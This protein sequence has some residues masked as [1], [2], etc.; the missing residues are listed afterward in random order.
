MRKAQKKLLLEFIQT[1]YQAQAQVKI[2]IDKKSF[3]QAGELLEQCQEGVIHL[4]SLIEKSEGENFVTVGLLEEYCEMVYHIYNDI[5]ENKTGGG[6]KIYKQL[7]KQLIRIENSVKSD[8]KQKIEAVFLP[9]NASM[10]DSLESVWKAA[11]EAEDCDAYVI[12]IPYY[13]KNP[14]GSFKEE[15]WE[16]DQ[17]PDYVPITRYQDYSFEEHHPDLIFI[18][19]PYDDL[20]MVT[21]V[22]PFF[23]SSNLKKY[24]DNLIYIPY[25]I[26]EEI[27]PDDQMTID[28]IQ[29][30]CTLPGVLNTDKVIVQSEGIRQIYINVLTK[31]VGTETRSYWEKKILGIGS[32]KM[33]KVLSTVKDELQIPEEWMNLIH[34]PD[35]NRKKIV[36]YNTSIGPLLQNDEKMLRKIKDVL[37][38]FKD[39]EDILTL[40]WRP[41]PLIKDT[42]ESMRP[43]LWNDYKDLVEW[44]R[45]GGWGIYDDSPDVERTMTLSDAYYG[46]NSS[47][48]PMYKKTHEFTLIQNVDIGIE[49]R[50]SYG[51]LEAAILVDHCI[52]GAAND[53][54]ALVKIDK[55]TNSMEMIER[56]PEED[57]LSVRLFGDVAYTN[58]KLIF[59]PM[60]ANNIVI[61]EIENKKFR[62]VPIDEKIVTGSRSYDKEHKF[63]RVIVRGEEAYIIG[64][65]FPAILKM[66]INNY[67]VNYI[68]DWVNV[69]NNLISD[70]NIVYFRSV[71]VLEGTEI[72]LPSYSCN[73]LVKFSLVEQE[74]QYYSIGKRENHYS[75]VEFDGKLFWLSSVN[76]HELISWDPQTCSIV[77]T[78]KKVKG[79]VT[80]RMFIENSMLYLIPWDDSNIWKVDIVTGRLVDRINIGSGYSGFLGCIKCDK[81]LFLLARE[82]EV[83]EV[84]DLEKFVWVEHYIEYTNDI[85]YKELCKR[86]MVLGLKEGRE[87]RLCDFLQILLEEDLTTV[88][89]CE[90]NKVGNKIFKLVSEIY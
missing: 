86:S 47:L 78:V 40:I 4:G 69:L 20:N 79:M 48:V 67:E 43:Q 72:W 6:S 22:H 11:D 45:E 52:W 15:R 10:W 23:Y 90:S 63:C 82:G 84:N 56:F 66:N 55:E 81:K 88:E 13:N 54:N 74:F 68:T 25:F 19:N 44:Y 18:H 83:I 32:P 73:M 8:I 87:T 36:F 17:Y 7:H 26:L 65:S 49:E 64:C 61:Y 71:Y 5:S 62:L 12:P 41:H 37:N 85:L 2:M 35:G 3:A 34:R 27:S 1:L 31:R 89:V 58:G 59:A 42:I 53:F 50:C 24:T 38:V 28:S 46:D 16:G 70:K 51:G 21:S 29:H 60:S 80:S 39:R 77:H 14:D 57:A 75:D 33:D 9:Y 76:G 30:F